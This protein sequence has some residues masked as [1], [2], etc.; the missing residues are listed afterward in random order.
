MKRIEIADFASASQEYVS[1]VEDDSLYVVIKLVSR[2]GSNY[3]ANTRIGNLDGRK[4]GSRQ[5]ERANALRTELL[6]QINDAVKKAGWTVSD[7]LGF[8][9][10][11]RG[12]AVSQDSVTVSNETALPSNANPQDSATSLEM[13]NVVSQDSVTHLQEAVTNAT[14]APIEVGNE[15]S[16]ESVTFGEQGERDKGNAVSQD[17]VTDSQGIS[18]SVSSVGVG[19]EDSQDSVTDL[20]Q[21]KQQQIT[22]RTY[23]RTI[24]TKL[25]TFKCVFCGTT[26]T[27]QRYPSPKRMYCSDSCKR[28][29]QKKQTKIRVQRL[30]ASRKANQV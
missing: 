13:S 1:F 24:T 2:S 22:A 16:Q 4:L 17:S 3:L 30:R 12:N 18:T 26:V 28:E 5:K 27:Q 15:Y 7:S 19:N 6:Q 21:G 25:V 9:A 8:T 29:T 23:T 10:Y 20:Q 11:K 14:I